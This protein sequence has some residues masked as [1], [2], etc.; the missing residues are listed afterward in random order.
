VPRNGGA[1][2]GA[3]HESHNRDV[4]FCVGGACYPGRV[5]VVTIG[6]H[7]YSLTGDTL[8][9]HFDGTIS[10]SDLE[11]LRAVITSLLEQAGHSFVI[12]D[13]ARSTGL[14]PDARKYLGEWSKQQSG[15][16][17]LSVTYGLSFAT[18]TMITLAVNAMKLLGKQDINVVLVKTEAEAL[19]WVEEQRALRFP[20]YRP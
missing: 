5:Q 16:N 17:S 1:P 7:P 13:M 8:H 11:A 18:R 3:P 9:I 12:G 10:V 19:A 4:G 6:R 15:K 20:D 14:D 2:A